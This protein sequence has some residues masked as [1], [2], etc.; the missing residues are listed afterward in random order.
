MC[1]SVFVSRRD[2]GLPSL[3]V[4]ACPRVYGEAVDCC[5]PVGGIPEGRGESSRPSFPVDGQVASVYY[6]CLVW[7]VWGAGGEENFGVRF[8]VSSSVRREA[9]S[10]DSTYFT[11]VYCGGQGNDPPSVRGKITLFL[12]T[13][14]ECPKESR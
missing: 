13:C 10:E 8:E 12:R 3:S 9:R 11:F 4:P 5:V 7:R 6:V 2:G 1:V 14:D